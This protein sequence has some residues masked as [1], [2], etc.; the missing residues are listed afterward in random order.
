M[1]FSTSAVA[2]CCLQR[3]LRL[4]EEADIVDGDDRLIGK[5]LQQLDLPIGVRAR[6]GS[7]G[8][9]DADRLAI[10]QHRHGE[11]GPKAGLYNGTRGIF[12]VG[13]DVRD[14]DDGAARIARPDA[15]PGW[16]GAGNVDSAPA[17]ASSGVL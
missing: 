15:V 10:A 14:M 13:G 7:R 16:G 6:I 11:N 17:K 8:V 3:F 4:V 9:D 2:V 1:T 12:G 5:C